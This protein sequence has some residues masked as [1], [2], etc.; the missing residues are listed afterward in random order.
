MAI[1]YCTKRFID[2]LKIW[3][4]ALEQQNLQRLLC[5][6]FGKLNDAIIRRVRQADAST[7]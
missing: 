2:K 3:L 7:F 1:P 5:L 4:Q 6:K